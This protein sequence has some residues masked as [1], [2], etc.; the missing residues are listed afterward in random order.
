MQKDKFNGKN[1]TKTGIS[2]K[3]KKMRTFF[4]KPLDKSKK[5]SILL[6]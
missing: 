3:N 1:A 2:T 4:A 6:A 5:R